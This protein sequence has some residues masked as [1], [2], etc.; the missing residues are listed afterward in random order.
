MAKYTPEQVLELFKKMP[1]HVQMSFHVGAQQAL[2]VFIGQIVRKYYSGKPGV[3]R[4]SGMLANSWYTSFK[5]EN[6]ENESVML[7]TS[8]RY[9]HVHEHANGFTGWIQAKNA[10]ALHFMVD[11]QHIFRKRVFIPKRTDVAGDWNRDASGLI[12]NAWVKNFKKMSGV[13]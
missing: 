3:N 8:V 5:N 2:Q 10:K 4:I 7:S 13:S 6:T 1:Q 11:G 12:I 9:A